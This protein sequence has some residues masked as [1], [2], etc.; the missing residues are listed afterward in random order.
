MAKAGW[1][2]VLFQWLALYMFETLFVRVYESSFGS[3][4]IPEL[5]FYSICLCKLALSLYSEFMRVSSVWFF[6]IVCVLNIHMCKFCE[7]ISIYCRQ[8]RYVPPPSTMLAKWSSFWVQRRGKWARKFV[9]N[10]T[11]CMDN[12]VG[13]S[14]SW[15]KSRWPGAES[16][17]CLWT[18]KIAKPCCTRCF[19]SWKLCVNVLTLAKHW[20]NR[21]VAAMPVDANCHG[22]FSDN[23]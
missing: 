17:E 9:T 7:H 23:N 22:L 1:G 3:C 15:T 20:P 12:W 18:K 8:F 11:I 10:W 16:R 14:M 21:S 6:Y 5:F 13:T 19:Q 2:S 4:C